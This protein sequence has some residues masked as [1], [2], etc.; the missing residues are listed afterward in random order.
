MVLGL[1][2]ALTL[3]PVGPA[4]TAQA[5][6]H[7]V[8]VRVVEGVRAERGDERLA[9]RPPGRQRRG[10]AELEGHLLSDRVRVRGRGRGRDRGWAT[11]SLY[12]AYISRASRVQTHRRAALAARG[13]G[14]R[15]RRGP[16]QPEHVDRKLDRAA[17]QPA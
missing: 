11:G 8:H 14:A 9:R 10:A 13:D 12:L 1:A 16:E 3:T 4:R 15:A 6:Q 17:R 2:L 7:H 5:A